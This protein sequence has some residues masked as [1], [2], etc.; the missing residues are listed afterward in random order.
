MD[1]KSSNG[2]GLRQSNQSNLTGS[3]DGRKMVLNLSASQEYIKYSW[4]LTFTANHSEH[5]GLSHLHCWKNSMNWT[6][7][8]WNYDVLSSEEKMEIKKATE[9]SYGVHVYDH[10]FMKKKL[11]LH[12]KHYLTVLGTTTGIFARDEYQATA[13]NLCHNHL[14]LAIDKESFN[15]ISQRYIHDLI[16]TSVVEIIKTDDDIERLLVNSLLKKLMK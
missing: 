15:D 14:I 7:K 2:I 9:E 11:L 6:S 8:I 4:F 3:V 10:W 5:P 16:Q 13:G 12:M 1:N